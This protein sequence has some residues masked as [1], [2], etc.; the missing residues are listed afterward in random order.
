MSN[1]FNL[2]LFKAVTIK[3]IPVLNYL[4]INRIKLS[5]NTQKDKSFAYK[6]Q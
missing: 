3:T 1:G 2:A 5:Q 6:P 4:L